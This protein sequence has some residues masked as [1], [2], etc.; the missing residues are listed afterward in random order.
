MKKP[1]ILLIC[2]FALLGTVLSS[3]ARATAPEGFPGGVT[4]YLSGAVLDTHQEPVREARLRVFVNGTPQKIT[5]GLEQ[6]DEI[7]TSSHGTY[8]IEFRLPPETAD[9]AQI[10]IEARKT[11]YRRAA[12]E[13]GKKDFAP[14]D[15]SLF[16][17]HNFEIARILGPAFYIATAIFLLIYLVISFDLLHRTIAALLGAG[18]M[19]IVTYTAGTLNPDYQIV[20]FARAISAID[21][22]VIFLL[23]GMMI[24]VGVLKHTGVFQ[25]CAYQAF[26]IARG[27]IFI[28]SAVSCLFVAITSAFLDNVTTML[29]Y[30]PVTIEVALALKISP[31]ILLIPEVM[32]SNVGGTATL[33]GDPPNIMIGSYTGLN[34]MDFVHNLT[35]VCVLAAVALII[36]SSFYYRKEYAQA[37]ISDIE[38]FIAKTK[39]QYKIT[40]RTLLGYGLFITG[41]AIALFITHGYWHMEVCIPALFGAGALFTYAVLT[42]KVKMLELIEKDIEWSTL[43]FFMFL[44]IVVSAVEETG[45]LALIADYVLKLSQGNLTAAICMILWVSAIMSAFIDNIPFTATMLP[46]TAYLTRVIPGAESNVL[47]WA[48]S[49]GACL[50]G[51]GTII[52]ASANVVTMGI[53]EKAGHPIRFFDFMKYAFPFMLIS[54]AICNVW[55]LIFY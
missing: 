27:N 1:A 49:L 17:V 28:L 43:L 21:M 5:S 37:K 29:L 25:W 7:E 33:I 19:L 30:T 10:K 45:L 15:Q 13:L 52:G 4:F 48:L 23:M 54:V 12:L 14:K 46:I 24:I 31:L 20:S 53:A 22:N 11:S 18:I 50:G 2:A 6:A 41:L 35:L 32:A 36:Y 47:F 8:Q 26:R 39:K 51:N 38:G 9:T 16:A 42:K 34:F 3:P 40:D 55:L 44:F